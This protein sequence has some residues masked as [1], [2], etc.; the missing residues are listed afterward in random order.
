MQKTFEQQF[1]L[2]MKVMD[3]LFGVLGV[4]YLFKPLDA[5]S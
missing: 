1:E 4:A 3:N 5:S 2:A